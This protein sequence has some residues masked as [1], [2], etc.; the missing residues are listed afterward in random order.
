[1]TWWCHNCVTLNVTKVYFTESKMNDFS[2]FSTHF[3]SIITLAF[4]G[5]FL[6]FLYQWKHEWILYRKF[7]KIYDN[8]LTMSPHTLPNTKTA[9]SETTVADSFLQRIRSNW[10]FATFTL[11]CLMFIFLIFKKM[12]K[13]FYQSSGRKYFT[14]S[15]VLIYILSSNSYI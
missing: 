3:V 1:M 6:Y 8:T 10:L 15:Q 5:Q 14:F 7:N 4:L 11:S 2:V 13:I 9:H 12:Y